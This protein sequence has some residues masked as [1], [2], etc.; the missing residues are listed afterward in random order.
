VKICPES[1]LALPSSEFTGQAFKSAE[2]TD[3]RHQYDKALG[4]D[5]RG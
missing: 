4:Q 2:N 3:L 1:L 5:G